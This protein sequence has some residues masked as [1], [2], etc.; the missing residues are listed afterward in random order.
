MD[1]Q[2]NDEVE[3][4]SST[5][6]EWLPGTVV[7]RKKGGDIEVKYKSRDGD[8]ERK[9]VPVFLQTTVVRWPGRPR[10]FSP[11]L[12]QI[13][14]DKEEGPDEPAEAP[15]AAEEPPAQEETKNKGGGGK[16]RRRSS[17]RRRRKSS[18]RR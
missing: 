10:I 18:R 4:Y 11:L 7:Q 6:R 3:V 17:K 9:E 16:R 2:V 8:E 1:W 13:A 12:A 14:K 15:A 5:K